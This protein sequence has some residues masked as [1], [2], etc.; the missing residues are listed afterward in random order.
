M[1]KSNLLKHDSTEQQKKLVRFSLL[2]LAFIFISLII[3]SLIIFTIN[4][5]KTSTIKILVA[6]SDAIVSIDGR[7]F[8]T[9]TTLKFRPGTYTLKIEKAGFVSLN[10]TITAEP[11]QT[12]YIYEYLTELDKNGTYYKDHEK[13]STRTQQIADYKADLLHETYTG[14]DQIWNVT[15]YN[16][17]NS[18]Y[19][20]S[21]EKNQDGRITINIYLY[22]CTNSRLEKL[23]SKALDYLEENKIDL[24]N[25]LIKY[26]NCS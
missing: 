8:S 3:Y 23:K 15:P 12:T 10:T 25:Y 19:K 18:G 7:D 2:F 13:E 14:T 5:D 1:Q 11:D 4:K 21:A 6:P 20:I 9:D 16:D 24:K 22:T 26:S 17:Y